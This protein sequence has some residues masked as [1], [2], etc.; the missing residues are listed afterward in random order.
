MPD[1]PFAKRV[2]KKKGITDLMKEHMQK[3]TGHV[4]RNLGGELAVEALNSGDRLGHKLTK[5]K[6]KRNA[7]N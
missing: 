3:L 2:Y 1:N 6:A 4:A 7:P 5:R